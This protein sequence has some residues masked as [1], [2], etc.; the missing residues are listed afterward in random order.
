MASTNLLER[1]VESMV[2]E[3]LENEEELCKC[4]QCKNDIMA[5]SLNNLRPR[6]AGSENGAVVLNSVD[7]SS[8]QTKMDVYRVV[9]KAAESVKER[10][11]HN[12]K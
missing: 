9:L 1:E 7:L 5:L 11:H 2:E 3:I 10:P 8:T 6:Y 12:R 4:E